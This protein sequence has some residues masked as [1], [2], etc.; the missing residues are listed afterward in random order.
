MLRAGRAR[1]ALDGTR[2]VVLVDGTVEPGW[3]PIAGLLYVALF[4]IAIVTTPDTGETNREILEHYAD[5]GNRRNDIV[6]TFLLA[7]ADLAFVWFAAAEGRGG[8]G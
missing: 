8:H 2:D 7:A 3:S 6:L 4:A 5:E 1:I